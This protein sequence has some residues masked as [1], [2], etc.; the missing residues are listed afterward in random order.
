MRGW[1]ALSVGV[2]LL[3]ASV[4][5]AGMNRI[6]HAAEPDAAD[7]NA[8]VISLWSGG[9]PD[10]AD[11]RDEPEI[12]QDW[13]VRN[14]HDPSLTVFP[15]GDN[16]SGTAVVIVPGGGHR[17]LVF[18]AEGT[19]MA[20]RFQSLGVSAF[21]LKHR[22]AREED[23]PYQIDVHAKADGQRAM[24]W[25][26]HHAAQYG[27]R[28]DRIGMM[29]FSAGGEVV[30][31]VT[32]GDTRPIAE[33]LDDIDRHPCGPNFQVMIYPGP[34]GIPDATDKKLPPAF[35]LVANDDGAVANI[36][37]ILSLYRAQKA[38]V[39]AHVFAAGGHGFNMGQ[40]ST[41]RSISSWPDRLDDWLVDGGWLTADSLEA[42][43][44]ASQP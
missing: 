22:L 14:I 36:L 3:T 2:T 16:N 33:P 21:V 37:K 9:A 23:S 5:P 18:D 17:L 26:R 31:M 44:E 20:K 43:P 4:N 32:Y 40:R 29:G 19:E 12:A 11:R 35:L 24:R 42:H 41:L 15:A 6:A 27:V 38:S 30:S 13:W 1:I 34:L 28:G 10:S 39:E 8:N 25:V 7:V